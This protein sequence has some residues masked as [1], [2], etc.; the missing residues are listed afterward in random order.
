MLYLYFQ[1]NLL[2]AKT[3]A[4]QLLSIRNK[5]EVSATISST[6]TYL[7]K[8]I[9]TNPSLLQNTYFCK[10]LFTDLDKSHVKLLAKSL[11]KLCL[12]DPDLDVLKIDA[13]TTN[14]NLLNM[15]VLETAKNVAK[16][17]ENGNSLSKMLGKSDFNMASFAKEVAIIDYFNEIKL[18]SE[19]QDVI[20]NSVN[21]F[22]QL[23]IHYLE[24]NYQLVAIFVMLAIKKCSSAKKLK[25]N[26]DYILQSI[27]E[28]SLQRPDLYQ[29]FPAESIFNFKDNS[30]LE[31][32]TLKIKTTNSLLIIKSLLEL[33]VKKVRIDSDQVKNIV[34]KLLK[35]NKKT[36]SDIASFNDPVF[37]ITCLILPSIVKQKKA[38]TTSAFRSILADLQEKLH[39]SLLDSFQ[40]IDLGNS[41]FSH[42]DVNNTEDSVVDSESS[43]ATLNAMV[44]YSLTLSRYCDAADGD[45][46]KNLECLLTALE[47]FVQNAVSII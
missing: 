17:F 9:S 30:L 40:N 4:L 22:K 14:R 18:D 6:K 26:I 27:Y 24:E 5:Q 11:V 39:K 29:I 35:K 32:L 38:I 3:M 21:I 44:A 23:P 36:I 28:L 7:I 10:I 43:V 20:K 25:R 2:L 12:T 31:L 16:F 13:I 1:D 42:N 45:D 46:A 34:E 33:A 37:Q 19:S 41:S 15:L 47:F 8:Q